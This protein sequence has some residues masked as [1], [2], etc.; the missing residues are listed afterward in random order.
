MASPSDVTDLDIF[1]SLWE[2]INDVCSPLPP[3]GAPAKSC[4]L[5]EMPG[6]TVDP[7]AFD[8]SKFDPTK[9][10]P[11]LET[12]NLCDRVPALARYFYDTGNHISFLWKQLLETFHIKPDPETEDKT[13]KQQYDEALKMLYGGP[14]G[15]VNQK[16]TPLFSNVDVLRGKWEDA[17]KE[18]ADYRNLCQSDTKNWPANF[19]KGAGPHREAVKQAYTEYNNLK[20][21]IEKYEAAIFAY[22]SG[23]LNTMMLKQENG[24]FVWTFRHNIS[25]NN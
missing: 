17:M 9:P 21:Q 25:Y 20:L 19:E 3:P 18:E 16:K 10:S 7:D 24:N 12:S 1:K 4:F 15:Y 11:D 6:F 8:P 22:A 14:D 2:N 23:D 5:M 13:I